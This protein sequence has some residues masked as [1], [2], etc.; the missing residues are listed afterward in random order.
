MFK[1]ESSAIMYDN[2]IIDYQ[3][4][5][6]ASVE[7][8]FI[9]MWEFK[10]FLKDQFNPKLLHFYHVHHLGFGTQMS[11]IDENCLIGL[12]IALGYEVH[13]SILTFKNENIFEYKRDIYHWN[14]KTNV[15]SST[16]SRAM[17]GRFLLSLLKNLSEGEAL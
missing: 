16:N 15:F 7:F 10:K 2:L 14:K 4:G 12:T 3:I 13:F 9:K 11:S 17:L 5:T 1:R 6:P 8:D